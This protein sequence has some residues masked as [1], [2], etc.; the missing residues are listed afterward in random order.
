MQLLNSAVTLLRDKVIEA[1][2][3]EEDLQERNEEASAKKLLD[4]REK[5][6]YHGLMN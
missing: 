4:A 3:A 1:D 6:R 2:V 5:G